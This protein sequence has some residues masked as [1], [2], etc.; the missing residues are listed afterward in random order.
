MTGNATAAERSCATCTHWSKEPRRRGDHFDYGACLAPVVRH[1][2]AT[3]VVVAFARC[4]RWEK[5]P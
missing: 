2:D 4:H 3:T 1:P 5:R